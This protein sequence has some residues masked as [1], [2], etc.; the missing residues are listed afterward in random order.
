M[1]FILSCIILLFL[2]FNFF[3]KKN[4]IWNAMFLF[5]FAFT[6]CGTLNED[7]YKFIFLMPHEWIILITFIFLLQLGMVKKRRYPFAITWI[8]KLFMFYLATAIAIPFL[9]NA[10]T[11]YLTTDEIFPFFLP[12]KIWMVYRIFHYLLSEEKLRNRNF[13]IAVKFDSFL[14]VFV[15]ISLISAFIGILRYVELPFITNFIDNSWPV[16]YNGVRVKATY[17][18]L[19]GTMSGENGTG[20][21]FAIAVM[22]SLYLY[23]KHRKQ[24]YLLSIAPLSFVTLLSGSISS[25]LTLL[26]ALALFIKKYFGL[27]LLGRLVLICL[28]FL[29]FFIGILSNKGINSSFMT[30]LENR[31]DY[32]Y[33]R[34]AYYSIADTMLPAQLVGRFHKWVRYWDYFLEK[35]IFGYSYEG[36]GS[37]DRSFAKAGGIVAENF[38][39]HL[40]I[41]SGIFGLLGYIVL[42]WTIISRL[43]RIIFYREQAFFIK[44]FI[45]MVL[46]SQ[47]SQLS[48][49]YGGI[50]ELFGIMSAFVVAFGQDE[51]TLMEMQV[52]N[53]QFQTAPVNAEV[54]S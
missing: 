5:T 37:R 11:L 20:L 30:M 1:I 45:G 22:S 21:F 28:I 23:N 15:I 46:I 8:D 49:Q 47:V 2:F 16:Y 10:E 17:G 27:K 25:N 13:D 14:K 32:N 24:F 39:V 19:T 53:P 31:Y 54:V 43:S 29:I 7:V 41:Y 33:G 42:N 50:S 9:A 48:F 26:I 35:P 4:D 52:I 40:L 12:I 3:V 44:L 6:M 18:R 34:S 38:Y 51:L 36:A